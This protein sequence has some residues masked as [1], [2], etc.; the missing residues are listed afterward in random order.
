MRIKI[1]GSAAGGGFPQ[2]NCGCANCTGVRRGSIKASPRT[3]TQIAIDANPEYAQRTHWAL[4]N[5]SPDLRTQILATPEL[6]PF[7]ST[8]NSSPIYDVYL[9]SADIDSL[10]GLLHLREF[11]GFKIHSTPSVRRIMDEENSIFRVLG[12]AT[13][14]VQWFSI[15]KANE[16]EPPSEAA[17][18]KAPQLRVRAIPLGND[19]PDYVS[20][21]LR[22]QL[23][24]RESVV[25]LDVEFNGKRVFVAPS[26]PGRD[27][28]WKAWARASDVV[29]IDG[30]FWSDN[31]LKQAGR[32]KKTAREMGHIPL[33]GPDGLLAQFPDDASARKILVHINNT[34]PILVEDS[35]ERRA[36]VDAGFEIAHDGMEITL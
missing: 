30:T 4:I 13:P 19:Y 6:A 29:L 11:Q 17:A 24:P 22:K 12:R 1:L 35:A 21:R 31:E 28:N 32:G 10:A 8:R 5:A 7:S 34:N 14:P 26:L 15:A 18:G 36:A 3:Q 9:T 25:A 2:W 23:E 33:S 20:E 27:T 16:I